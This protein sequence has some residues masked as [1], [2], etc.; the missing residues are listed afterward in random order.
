MKSDFIL[1]FT[2]LFF[3]FGY[4]HIKAIGVARIR[5]SG[6]S[7][8][9]MPAVTSMSNLTHPRSPLLKASEGALSSTSIGS[10]YK[11][12]L[13][14]LAVKRFLYKICKYMNGRLNLHS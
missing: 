11:I 9:L 5:F 8:V 2:F 4:F 13:I 12:L 3:E 14:L 10:K 1:F 7:T 6:L